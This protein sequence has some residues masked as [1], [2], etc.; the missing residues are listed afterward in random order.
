MNQVDRTIKR[1]SEM[2]AIMDQALKIMD[3]VKESP[4]SFIGFQ[5]EIKRLEDY[6]SSR[7][8]KDDFALDEKGILPD[9]LKRGV[10][11]EDGIY[12]LLER[13]A[14]LLNSLEGISHLR[15]GV[16]VTNNKHCRFVIARLDTVDYPLLFLRKWT[17][18]PEDG[19]DEY[20]TL[21][22]SGFTAE[23]AD[24]ILD[25]LK[26]DNMRKARTT[27]NHKFK[28]EGILCEFV[29]EMRLDDAVPDDWYDAWK[30]MKGIITFRSDHPGY[31]ETTIENMDLF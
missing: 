21:Y 20:Y 31:Y 6:Y 5:P 30:E 16:I 1:V 2:E 14:D 7:D 11:S 17:N 15:Y 8:W 29:G 24:E 10:L 3:N 18:D 12:N 19:Y 23:E 28:E 9:Y 4:E 27:L 22:K 25:L 13:N 26:A